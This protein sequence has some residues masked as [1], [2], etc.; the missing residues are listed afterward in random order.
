MNIPSR[1]SPWT[2]ATTFVQGY[3]MVSLGKRFS[4]EKVQ[5]TISLLN[6]H[7]YLRGGLL[8]NLPGLVGSKSPGGL[9]E[10]LFVAEEDAK[11]Y[12]SPKFQ[13]I[14]KTGL[15]QTI[16][17]VFV[18]SLALKNLL[19]KMIVEEVLD[20]SQPIYYCNSCNEFGFGIECYRG[21]GHK[22]NVMQ[23]YSLSEF[24]LQ[25]WCKEPEKFLE[26]MCYVALRNSNL[27]GVRKISHSVSYRRRGKTDT[28]GEIDVLVQ[29]HD[30]DLSGRFKN[31]NKKLLAILCTTSVTSD[32]KKQIKK[33][34]E[35]KVP[36]IFVTT[37]NSP[38][39][40]CLNCFTGVKKDNN[41]PKNFVEYV[42][43]IIP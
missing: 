14:S 1:P 16:S 8:S 26:G 25:I 11:V 21:P 33:L 13:N 36:S 3:T 27:A 9:V 29:L 4:D 34:N 40:G 32:E 6:E 43:S 38:V 28:D 24:F 23:T 19:R 20:K 10:N 39:K 37:G 12:M 30:L 41:F 18:R 7:V 42:N 15:T 35:L 2:H 31:Y 17:K 22:V 5:K